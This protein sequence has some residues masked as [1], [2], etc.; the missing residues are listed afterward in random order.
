[1]VALEDFVIRPIEAR[2]NAAIARLIRSVMPEFGA[3]G[4]G[5]AISDPEVDD[6]FAGYVGPQARYYVVESQEEIA[7]GGGFATLIGGGAEVCEVRKMYFLP[8][9]RGLGVGA[10]LLDLI[11]VA[12]K[13]AGFTRC[14]LETLT[15]MIPAQKLYRSRGF[16]QLNEPLG[17]TGHGGCNVW[18]ARSLLD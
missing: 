11:L 18:M 4:P 9:A 3:I 14:Y 13:G 10:R 15:N 7:G 6:M 8:K 12:A 17:A 2:D 5:Y 1:M 16:E